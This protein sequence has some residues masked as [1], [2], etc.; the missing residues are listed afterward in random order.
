MIKVTIWRTGT[1]FIRRFEAAGHA[2]YGPVG[3]DIICSA[4]TAI[5]S[6]AIGS[7]QDIAKL[8]VE[9]I[10]KDGLIACL[11]PEKTAMTG[12]QYQTAAVIL[13]SMLLGCRQIENSYGRTYV[14]V[15]EKMFQQGGT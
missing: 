4:I 3:T 5:T 10:L 11:I 13:E 14:Q 6:T 8:Q 1:G 12:E 15:R 2:G 7:L 9:A